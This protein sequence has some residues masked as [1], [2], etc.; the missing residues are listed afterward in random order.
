MAIQCNKIA[1]N[2]YLLTLSSIPLRSV[3]LSNKH[4]SSLMTLD[5]QEDSLVLAHLILKSMESSIGESP[6]LRLS[7]CYVNLWAYFGLV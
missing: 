2:S 3:T 5:V 7:L 1:I 6:D 4:L